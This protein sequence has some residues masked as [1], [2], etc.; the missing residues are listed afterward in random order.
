M[1]K[2]RKQAA[3]LSKRET[4]IMDIVYSRGECS[5]SDVLEAMHDPPGYSSVRKLLSILAEKGHLKYRQ[6]GGKYIYRPTKPRHKAGQSALARVLATFYENSVEQAVAAM[7][8]SREIS[9]SEEELQRLAE[10]I[11]E[12][13]QEGQP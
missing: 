5:V 9:P 7:L 10:L 1:R 12:A 6:E 13:K 8:S 3:A 11:E 2:K 4:Q